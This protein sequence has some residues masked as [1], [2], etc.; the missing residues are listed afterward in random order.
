M[1]RI[2]DNKLIIE[3]E[4]SHPESLLPQ[5]QKS[6]ISMLQGANASDIGIEQSEFYI[7]TLLLEALLPTH[8]QMQE[9]KK[10][11]IFKITEKVA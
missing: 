4:D 6:L 5:I 7:Y 1:I 9:G 8:Y 10:K 2:E 3:I 11:G